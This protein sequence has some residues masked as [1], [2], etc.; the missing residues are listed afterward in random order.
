M[1]TIKPPVITQSFNFSPQSIL[2]YKPS[3]KLS[4]SEYKKLKKRYEQS[5][6]DDL[7]VGTVIGKGDYPKQPS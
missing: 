6:S 1:P 7:P 4:K 2:E 5:K 3:I